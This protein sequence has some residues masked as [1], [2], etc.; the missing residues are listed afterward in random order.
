MVHL[1]HIYRV[2]YRDQFTLKLYFG[3]GFKG[4]FMYVDC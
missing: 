4:Y 3:E 2:R 1:D